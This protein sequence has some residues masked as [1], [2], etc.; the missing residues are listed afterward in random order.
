AVRRD[1]KNSNA[2]SFELMDTP[3]TFNL[4]LVHK[5]FLGDGINIGKTLGALCEV[6]HQYSCDMLLL[7]G[8]PSRLP[9]IQAFLRKMLPLPPGRI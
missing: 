4:P 1:V 9:G 7:T 2:S 6:I 8:R 5:A 3:I